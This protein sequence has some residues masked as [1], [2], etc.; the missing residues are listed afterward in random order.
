MSFSDGFKQLRN[1]ASWIFIKI[2]MLCKIICWLRKLPSVFQFL[3]PFWIR[4]SRL[5]NLSRGLNF[6]KLSQWIPKP[7]KPFGCLPNQSLKHS[8]QHFSSIPTF[9]AA[10]KKIRF[11]F[12]PHLKICLSLNIWFF[13][14]KTSSYISATRKDRNPN[15]IFL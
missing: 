2:C 3:A 12:S 5:S 1:L 15:G 8:E 6:L 4:Q 13:V 7:S 11:F 9:L 14:F 10:I